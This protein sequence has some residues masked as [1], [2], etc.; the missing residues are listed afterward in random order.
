MNLAVVVMAVGALLAVLCGACTVVS[1]VSSKD[2]LTALAVG[3]APTIIGI[4]LFVTG[5]LLLL[6]R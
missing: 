3:G 6:R 4:G 5:L 2:D 1:I